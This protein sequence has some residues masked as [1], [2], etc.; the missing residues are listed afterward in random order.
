MFFY[1]NRGFDFQSKA[2]MAHNYDCDL[3]H[4]PKHYKSH[5]R[6]YNRVY[7]YLLL[8]FTNLGRNGD[9]DKFVLLPFLHSMASRNKGEIE[10]HCCLLVGKNKH[11]SE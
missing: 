3:L 4:T 7:S 9:T 1:F 8:F 10:L 5:F 2:N 6:S 11:S